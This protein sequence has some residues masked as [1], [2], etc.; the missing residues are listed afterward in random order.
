MAEMVDMIVVVMVKRGDKRLARRR[1]RRKG[2]RK[3]GWE[4]ERRDIYTQ[5]GDLART[6]TVA[7]ATQET[8][9]EF[10]LLSL[11]VCGRA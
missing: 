7:L 10:S 3:G 8:K 2:E 6:V 11:C 4:V 5:L 1:R 9:K